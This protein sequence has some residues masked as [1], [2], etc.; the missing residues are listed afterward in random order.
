MCV[1]VCSC[2]WIKSAY[3]DRF[4]DSPGGPLVP[5]VVFQRNDVHV[6]P[7]WGR[8]PPELQEVSLQGHLDVHRRIWFYCKNTQERRIIVPSQLP[9]WTAGLFVSRMSSSMKLDR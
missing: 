2:I 3:V 8:G 9:C 5:D 4:Q 1:C 7:G 6:S